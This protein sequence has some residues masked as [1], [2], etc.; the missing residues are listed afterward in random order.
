M[1]GTRVYGKKKTDS[2]KLDPKIINTHFS[3]LTVGR[4]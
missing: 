3:G 1:R 4:G 2:V